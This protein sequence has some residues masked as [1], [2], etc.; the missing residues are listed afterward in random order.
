MSHVEKKYKL[1]LEDADITIKQRPD[2]DAV[3]E[4]VVNMMGDYL[5]FTVTDYKREYVHI[6]YVVEDIV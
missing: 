4:V 5:C 6:H 1:V 2:D 3:T